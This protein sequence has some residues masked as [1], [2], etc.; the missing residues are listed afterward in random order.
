MKR[1][2][3]G[4][5]ALVAGIAFCM[6]AHAEEDGKRKRGRRAWAH[7]K[8][9]ESGQGLKKGHDKHHRRRMRRRGAQGSDQGAKNCSC[10]CHGKKKRKGQSARRKKFANLT[11]EQK[12]KLQARR[13]AR[14]EARKAKFESMTPEQRKEMMKKRQARRKKGGHKCSC[15]HGNGSHGHHGKRARGKKRRKGN[16]GLGNGQDPQPPGNPK[17]NDGAGTG[18][19]DPGVRK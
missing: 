11:A 7:K 15:N 18:P 13:K 19:G 17:R 6:P 14:C 1:S 8:A 5:I 12:Q 9:H 16:N 4:L 10:N 2:I 3:V